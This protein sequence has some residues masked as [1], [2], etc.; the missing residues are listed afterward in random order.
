MDLVL[1]WRKR[2]CWWNYIRE[3]YVYNGTLC[4]R[5]ATEPI[6]IF[7]KPCRHLIEWKTK[8]K[9]QQRILPT[10]FTASPLSNTILYLC[11]WLCNL[12]RHSLISQ[13]VQ[14]SSG[15]SNYLTTLHWTHTKRVCHSPKNV[16][17]NLIFSS[18]E[19]LVFEI[20]WALILYTFGVWNI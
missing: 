13:L 4:T 12:V 10:I 2:K 20:N 7:C 19:Q 15:D 14:R 18:W 3:I 17:K 1:L 16:R 6:L 8:V 9:F 11:R 5:D